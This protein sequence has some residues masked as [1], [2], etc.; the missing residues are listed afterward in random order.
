MAHEPRDLGAMTSTLLE[1]NAIERKYGTETVLSGLDFAAERG[2]YISIRGLSGAGKS[3]FLN[4]LG[5]LDRPTDGSY[6]LEGVEVSSLPDRKRSAIRGS[7][8]GFVFQSFHL[9]PERSVVENVLFAERYHA[10]G[11]SDLHERSLS[12]LELVGLGHRLDARP[13]TLSAGER[14]RVAIARAVVSRPALLLADEPTGTLTL[15]PRAASSS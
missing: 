6:R 7:R 12:A 2:D 3:T 11:G 9:L 15:R 4:I 8:I 14:Q 13:E 5:L 1:L 10:D